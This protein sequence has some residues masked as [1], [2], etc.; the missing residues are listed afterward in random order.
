MGK[1]FLW[2]KGYVFVFYVWNVLWI[3][4]FV[5]MEFKKSLEKKF[6]DVKMYIL[7]NIDDFN[8]FILI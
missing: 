3:F 7:W 2:Y 6:K 4:L 1:F 8:K 5:I